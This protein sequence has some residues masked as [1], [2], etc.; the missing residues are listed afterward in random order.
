MKAFIWLLG[1]TLLQDVVLE[2]AYALDACPQGVLG[3]NAQQFSNMWN[4]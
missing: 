2:K 1:A 3:I 4:I